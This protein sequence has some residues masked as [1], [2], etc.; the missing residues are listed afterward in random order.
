MKSIIFSTSQT[1]NTF[2]DHLRFNKEFDRFN[3]FGILDDDDS[4]KGKTFFGLNV[5]GKWNEVERLM[6]EEG[7]TH[8][9]VGLAA[10][11]HMLIKNAIYKYCI[12]LGLKPISSIH[13]MAYVSASA[14]LDDGQ[15]ILPFVS[16]S[17]DCK[18]ARNC[19]IH[20]GTV[21]LEDSTLEENVLV[22][23]NSFVGGHTHLEHNVY[24]GPGCTIGSRVRIGHN[25]IVGAGSTVIKNLPPNSFAYG[26]PISV[27]KEN[28]HYHPV[29]EWL[30]KQ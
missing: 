28:T 1:T 26:N 11:K 27:V 20:S 18:I 19:S 3:F 2:L 21:I 5:I 8:F 12:N 24:I 15:L 13:G 23:G 14:T 22:A 16:V 10:T 6:L 29:P 30:Q 4:K 25:T 7:V 17:P 9:G